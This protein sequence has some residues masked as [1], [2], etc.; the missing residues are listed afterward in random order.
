MDAFESAAAV[1]QVARLQ[2]S[3]GSRTSLWLA[4]LIFPVNSDSQKLISVPTC[5]REILIWVEKNKT[6]RFYKIR[7]G[8]YK[9]I[10]GKI[11]CTH[12]V[13]LHKFGNYVRVGGYFELP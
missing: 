5:E 12:P 7:G 13:L 1:L 3:G 6:M 10:H 9:T 11:F 2:S 8:T 4:Q